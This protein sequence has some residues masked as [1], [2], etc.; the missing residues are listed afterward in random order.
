MTEP[1]TRSSEVVWS[2]FSYSQSFRVFLDDVP[3]HFLRDLRSPNNPFAA[4]A[5]ED[6]TVRDFGNSRPVIDRLLHPTGHRD[7]ANV[8]SFPNEV[9]YGSVV[10]AALHMVKGQINEF[11]STEPTA[12]QNR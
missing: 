8:P 6:L 11:S 12:Q 7:R 2:Q 4:N 9:N 10:F 5:S 3:G 1:G